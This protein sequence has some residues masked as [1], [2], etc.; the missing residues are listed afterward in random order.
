MSFI[1]DSTQSFY[2][3]IHVFKHYLYFV[4]PED[5]NDDLSDV[6]V[7]LIVIPEPYVLHD[8]IQQR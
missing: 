6:L 3:F 8:Y 5:H 7:Y 1:K 2:R 4:Y